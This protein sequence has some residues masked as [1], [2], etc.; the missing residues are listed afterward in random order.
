M[1]PKRSFFFL[2]VALA[3]SAGPLAHLCE[4]RNDNAAVRYWSA[5][6]VMR[7]SSI[8]TEQARQLNTILEGKV[9]YDDSQFK[10]L[11]EK[12]HLSLEI[13]AR[14]TSLPTCDWG[15]D[16]SFGSDEPVEYARSA[17]VLGRL[18]V[19]YAL[20]LMSIGDTNAAVE[21]LTVGLRFS[22]DVANGGTLFA[23]LA[24]DRLISDHLRVIVSAERNSRLSSAQ[25]STLQEAVTRLGPDGLDWQSALSREFAVH[26]VE[27]A[28][29]RQALA[30]L[31]RIESGYS[32]A[33]KNS[34]ELPGLENAVRS[35]PSSMK[36]LIPDPHRVIEAKDDLSAQI[37]Q[38]RSSLR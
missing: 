2:F 26:H 18:N 28:H 19:L 38:A 22:Q 31:S 11:I 30:V 17:L 33:L 34:S 3:L 6:S 25:R 14:A 16:Y 7:D 29:N 21:T 24:A 9:P 36:Q 10:D 8:S 20:H 27:F 35:A 13:M 1:T 37:A 32:E 23:T 5:F 4:A 15:L 12:N